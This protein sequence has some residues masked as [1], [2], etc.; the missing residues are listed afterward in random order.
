MAHTVHA[1][2]YLGAFNA[3]MDPR[4]LCVAQALMAIREEALT[5]PAD[6]D[7]WL[8]DTFPLADEADAPATLRLEVRKKG[9]HVESI[10][11][12]SSS[13]AHVG[14]HSSASIQL[15]HPSISRRHAAILRGA[16]GKL[17]LVDLAS[18]AGLQLNGRKVICH[19]GLGRLAD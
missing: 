14:K 19:L 3:L 7:A 11:L 2:S 12:G 6:I 13:L 16:D 10:D 17:V 18:K 1:L 8:R 5:S 15:E 4:L 9:E